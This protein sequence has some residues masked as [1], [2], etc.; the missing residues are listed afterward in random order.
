[1]KNEKATALTVADRSFAEPILP[2]ERNFKASELTQFLELLGKDAAATWLRFIKPGNKG[3][4][5]RQGLE[6]NWINSKTEAGLN[7]F[8]VIG[9]ATA[10][11]GKGGGSP[12]QT[13]PECRRCLLS[14][15]MAPASKNRCSG[16][17]R[18]G[19][20]SHR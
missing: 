18:W 2:A 8:G 7:L 20:L 12:M 19:C 17:S 14:G 1:M 3:A 5:E 10:A 13:S 6:L 4:Y 15:M 9:N 16:G 11:T